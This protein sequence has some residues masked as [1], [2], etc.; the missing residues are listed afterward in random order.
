MAMPKGLIVVFGCWFGSLVPFDLS[1]QVPKDMLIAPAST[2]V[3]PQDTI[4]QRDLIRIFLNITKWHPKKPPT[5]DGRR[6]Y[7]SFLPLSTS[8][9]GG[10][11]ALITSTTAGFYLGNRKE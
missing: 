11:T 8:V 7:Y 4:G 1:A 10:G 3:K 9:P 6:V 5:V 2:A